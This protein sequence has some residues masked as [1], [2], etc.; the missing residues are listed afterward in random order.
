MKVA[1]HAS[2]RK[3]ANPPSPVTPL[4]DIDVP[5]VRKGQAV[6]ASAKYGAIRHSTAHEATADETEV[7]T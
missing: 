2:D 1:S 5:A 6:A 3:A 7:S 4:V